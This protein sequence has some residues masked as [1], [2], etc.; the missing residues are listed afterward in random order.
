M[1]VPALLVTGVDPDT[2]ASTLLSLGWDLPRDLARLGGGRHRSR[3]RSRVAGRPADMPVWAGAGGQ[4][5]V[6]PGG[7]WGRTAPLTR[8]VVTGVGVPPAGLRQAFD[9]M[10]LSPGDRVDGP[11]GGEDGLEPWLGPVRD[12]A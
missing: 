3:G 12:V 1:T 2:M 4:L 11:T 9:A 7:S 6:G 8:N 5:S 10:L